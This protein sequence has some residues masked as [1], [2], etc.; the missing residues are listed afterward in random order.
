[1]ARIVGGT[2]V[3]PNEWA[4][5]VFITIDAGGLSYQH[6]CSGTLIDSKTVLTNGECN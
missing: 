4:A 5:H 1:M 2:T 6:N 3:K